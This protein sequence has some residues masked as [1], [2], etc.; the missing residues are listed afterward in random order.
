MIP[1]KRHREYRFDMTAI[2]KTESERNF[3]AFMSKLPD[4]LPD[5]EGQFALLH[6]QNIVGY[7]GSAA[8]GVIEGMKRYGADSY[9]VQEV[10]D[11]VEDLGFYSH[12]GGLL[13][14]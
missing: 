3:A 7:F 8:D 2:P 6:A 13:Q 1:V 10:T 11:A 14:A 12:A 9:S 5:H 4:L